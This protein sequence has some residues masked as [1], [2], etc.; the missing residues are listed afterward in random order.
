[1]RVDE[2]ETFVFQDYVNVDTYFNFPSSRFYLFT[3]ILFI[4][5]PLLRP[6]SYGYCSWAHLHTRE[7]NIN[8][9]VFWDAGLVLDKVSC[10]DTSWE[11][12]EKN[13]GFLI[14]SRL[15]TKKQIDILFVDV[16]GEKCDKISRF[17]FSNLEIIKIRSLSEIVVDLEGN[18]SIVDIFALYKV[19]PKWRSP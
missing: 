4:S 9:Y 5:F 16:Q 1:M 7:K 14:F 8:F 6:Y 12:G 2:W 13:V 19:E 15:F 18:S 11:L 17:F 3:Y 10:G